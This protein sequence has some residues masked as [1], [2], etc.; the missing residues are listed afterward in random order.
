MDIEKIGFLYEPYGIFVKVTLIF[1]FKENLLTILLKIF[2]KIL[3]IKKVRIVLGQYTI[4]LKVTGYL[5]L[6]RFSLSS[7]WSH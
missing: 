1:D 5:I 4:F 6:R 7:Y 2:L 3:D